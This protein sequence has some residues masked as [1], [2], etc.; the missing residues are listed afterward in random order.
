VARAVRSEGA[1]TRQRILSEARTLFLKRGY[2]GTTVSQLARASGVTTPALY[3]HFTSKEDLYFEVV[4]GEYKD[5]LDALV[6]VSLEG[7]AEERLRA[8][9]KTFVAF[10]L[11]A[12][13]LS[14]MY[15]F[16]QLKAALS[17]QRAAVISALQREYLS[18][19]DDILQ[20]GQREG[21][22][23]PTDLRVAAFA[24]ATM[25]EYVFLWFRHGGRLSVS[26][27]GD[28][29]AEFALGIARHGAPGPTLRPA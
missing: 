17:P 21:T 29:Y 28:L 12:G 3:W 19:L 7:S 20:Q 1:I 26:E 5:M 4:H 14:L 9:V 24:I 11:P 22:F 23:A 2:E 6:A 10:Q 15:G 8:Y 13:D 27:V 16:S 18:P 25:C